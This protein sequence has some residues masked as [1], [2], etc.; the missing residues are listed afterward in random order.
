M[1]L[2]RATIDGRLEM[3]YTW[4]LFYRPLAQQIERAKS[5]F[6]DADDAVR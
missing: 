2:F 6:V 5:G 4:I 3:F 1:I